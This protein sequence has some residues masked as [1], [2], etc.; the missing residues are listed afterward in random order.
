MV[1]SRKKIAWA[2]VCPPQFIK[3]RLTAESTLTANGLVDHEE[4]VNFFKLKSILA[5]K[6]FLRRYSINSDDPFFVHNAEHSE[7]GIRIS[8]VAL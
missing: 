4:K 5:K 3:K 8:S 6:E 1:S 2:E 7:P